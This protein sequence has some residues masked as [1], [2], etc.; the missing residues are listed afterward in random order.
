MRELHHVLH[1]S[2]SLQPAFLAWKFIPYYGEGG[3]LHGGRG[4]I[5]G[6]AAAAILSFNTSD[7]VAAA[8]Q[9]QL[10]IHSGSLSVQSPSSH[11]HVCSG[12]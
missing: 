4:G 12:Q 6:S 9:F 5:R 8:V 2:V 11:L 3:G 10:I 1:F 7:T